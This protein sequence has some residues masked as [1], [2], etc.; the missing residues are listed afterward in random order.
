MFDRGLS[1][2]R[3]D[4]FNKREKAYLCNVNFVLFLCRDAACAWDKKLPESL[5]FVYR[6]FIELTASLRYG[7]STITETKSPIRPRKGLVSS[8]IRPESLIPTL[9]NIRSPVP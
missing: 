4:S 2:F 7:S 9:F 1:I 3:D 5:M 8:Q 6:L